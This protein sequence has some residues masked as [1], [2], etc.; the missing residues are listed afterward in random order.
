MTVYVITNLKANHNPDNPDLH[1]R[2]SV[3]PRLLVSDHP[4][5]F[6]LTDE[7]PIKTPEFS[8]AIWEVELDPVLHKAGKDHLAEWSFLLAEEK[9]GFCSYPFFMISSRFYMKNE[10]LLT[11]LNKEWNTL[12]SHFNSYTHGFLPSYC[13]PMRWVKFSALINNPRV[14]FPFSQK[15]F[16][17]TEDLFQTRIPENYPVFPDLG[18][19]YLGFKDRKA[20]L[21][22]VGFYKPILNYFFTDNFKQTHD[23]ASF[24]RKSGHYPNEKP[25]T[26]LF[27]TLSH[28]Y[29]H[30]TQ[31]KFFALHYDGYYDVDLQAKKMRRLSAFKIPVLTKIK[32][33]L[34]WQKWWFLTEGP[35]QHVYSMMLSV[36]RFY[37]KYRCWSK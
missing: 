11:D 24:V 10:W 20:L 30:K 9:Y 17:L 21:D 22:Y 34:K 7:K 23:I 37:K 2:L 8:N 29:F 16:K 14:F 25:L 5:V 33:A 35:Y 26:F 18:C 31:T 27:E 6:Y 13:R 15:F 12:F 28:L 4:Y 36:W 32:R 1:R 3:D 19:H